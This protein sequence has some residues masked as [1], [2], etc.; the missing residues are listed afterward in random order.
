LKN[1]VI[2]T[3]GRDS[4]VQLG[5]CLG[6]LFAVE[7]LAPSSEIYLFSPWVS[8]M[9]I[10]N[11]NQGQFRSLIPELTADWINLSTLLNILSERGSKVRIICRSGQQQ[12]ED[13]LKLMRPEIAHKSTDNWHE[14]GLTTEQFYLRGSMN[15]TYAGV[16]LNDENIEITTETDQ[17]AHAYISAQERWNTLK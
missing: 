2:K 16:N 9:P 17:V 1:R 15:F 13:F 4:S 8:D 10:L 5:E 6:S 12:N 3:S 7:L 11:N 14:K